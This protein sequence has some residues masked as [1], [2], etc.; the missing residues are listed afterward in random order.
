[1]IAK[2][3]PT[4][5]ALVDFCNGQGIKKNDIVHISQNGDI[6]DTY[7]VLIYYGREGTDN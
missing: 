2:Q 7:Y 5:R 4:L 3:F 6:I 1:M